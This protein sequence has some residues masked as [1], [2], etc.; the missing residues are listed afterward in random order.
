MA[1]ATRTADAGNAA[2]SKLLCLTMSYNPRQ[3]RTPSSNGRLSFGLI[4]LLSDLLHFWTGEFIR[5]LSGFAGSALKESQSNVL[6]REA[7][8]FVV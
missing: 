3:S 2:V 4:G 8:Y 1:S 6:K 5:H 7:I